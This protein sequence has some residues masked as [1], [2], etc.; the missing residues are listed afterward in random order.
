MAALYFAFVEKNSAENFSRCPLLACVE[1][2][3]SE[4]LQ[5]SKG[6]HFLFLV[7]GLLVLHE[8]L[9]FFG[10]IR[11]KM[12]DFLTV[13]ILLMNQIAAFYT[14]HCL[15]TSFRFVVPKLFTLGLHRYRP[16]S[17]SLYL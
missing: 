7:F 4:Q 8:S 17:K 13:E 9:F 14:F 15:G 6:L 2:V 1:A 11:S 12:S 5:P 10:H 16:T 3:S